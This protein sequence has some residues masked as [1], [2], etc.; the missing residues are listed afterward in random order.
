MDIKSTQYRGKLKKITHA[1]VASCLKSSWRRKEVIKNLVVSDLHGLET[2]YHR[3]PQDNQSVLLDERSTVLLGERS[4]KT[5]IQYIAALC[6]HHV[7]IREN[8]ELKFGPHEPHLRLCLL[9][10]LV[11]VHTDRVLCGHANRASLSCVS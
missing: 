11:K 6:N 7:K 10:H 8:N 4:P 5:L 1:D 9:C 2:Q 3:L